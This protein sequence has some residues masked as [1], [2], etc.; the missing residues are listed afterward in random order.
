MRYR[1]S[2]L[3]TAR[4][5]SFMNVCG[6]AIA[7]RTPSIDPSAMRESAAF[8]LNSARARFASRDAT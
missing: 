3:R 4:P 2:S 5:E 1:S 7:T 8:V 6:R